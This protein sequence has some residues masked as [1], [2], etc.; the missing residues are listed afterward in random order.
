MSIL[1]IA[2]NKNVKTTNWNTNARSSYSIFYVF[3]PAKRALSLLG[4]KQQ[5]G[6]AE[7]LVESEKSTEKSEEKLLEGKR[8]RRYTCWSHRRRARWCCIPRTG[9]WTSSCGPKRPPRPSATSSS[10]ASKATTTTP[11][12]T[13]SSRVSSF[14][15]AIP[16]VLAR[17]RTPS[18]FSFSTASKDQRIRSKL[19][20]IPLQFRSIEH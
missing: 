20:F 15:V 3:L 5:S 4:N 13:A 17:V 6:R 2:K 19:S 7:A 11:S 16:P 12:S 1:G 9:R 8:C 14:R 10:S 18:Q